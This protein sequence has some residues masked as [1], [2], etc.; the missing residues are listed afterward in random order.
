MGQLTPRERE[1]ATM[2]ARGARRC[3]IAAALCVTPRTVKA[4]IDNAR[5]RTGA[6]TA[7]E[8]AAKVAVELPGSD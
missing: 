4:H 1:V 7:A 6:R 3:E 8:L 2:L 5:A